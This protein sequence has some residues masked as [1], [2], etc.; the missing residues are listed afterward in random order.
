MKPAI[1]LGLAI[2]VGAAE[3]AVDPTFYRISMGTAAVA[4]APMTSGTCRVQPVFGDGSGKTA[5][6][7]GL[8]R[9]ARIVV[10][11]NGK[12]AAA[13]YAKEEQTW[14]VLKGEAKLNGRALRTDD[15]VYIPAGERV[16]LA[17]GSG[18]VEVLQIGYLVPEGAKGGTQVE[19]ANAGNVKKQTVGNHPASTLY[20]L[21]VGGT[22]STRDRIAAGASLTSLFIMDMAPGGTN[23][24]HHHDR[25]EELYVV[26]GGSGDLVAGGGANGVEGKF[27]VKAGDACLYRLNA[28]MGFYNTGRGQARILAA[29]WKY[30]FA[31]EKE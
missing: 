14:F 1:F 15:F 27:A 10:D 12:C 23:F 20:Q 26:I 6:V 19:V 25:E 30:P 24:P 11:A 21:L 22:A 16:E 18:A 31:K 4:P 28:T 13:S 9:F 7:R 5:G 8:G 17:A 3:R 29:R 2:V